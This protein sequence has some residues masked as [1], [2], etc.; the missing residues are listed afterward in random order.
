MVFRGSASALAKSF[1]KFGPELL[2]L[3]LAVIYRKAYQNPSMN[4]SNNKMTSMISFSGWFSQEMMRENSVK[5]TDMSSMENLN[6][7]SN[8]HDMS[9]QKATKIMCHLA[10]V[11]STVESMAHHPGILK[12]LKDII[13]SRNQNSEDQLVCFT[14]TDDESS[15]NCLW[16][17][18]N[19]AC[20]PGNMEHMM[21]YPGLQKTL[22]NVIRSCNPTNYQRVHSPS[23]VKAIAAAG[24]AVR[25]FLNLSWTDENKTRMSENLELIDET[26]KLV[27]SLNQQSSKKVNSLV[28]STR[29]HAIGTLRN[30]AAT[31]SFAAKLRLC[32]YQNNILLT[33][34][35]KVITDKVQ[36][37]HMTEG[38]KEDLV[39]KERALA[40]IYNLMCKETVNSIAMHDG[41]YNEIS[42]VPNNLGKDAGDISKLVEKVLMSFKEHVKSDMECYN[43]ITNAVV[44]NKPE[45]V[46]STTE[47]TT[48]GE[49]SQ[50]T[51][52]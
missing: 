5:F 17:L 40:T 37:D 32:Q 45:R 33:S 22:L 30:I 43:M 21:G 41:L 38:W 12:V 3:L 24:Q 9:I 27:S 14:N 16:I 35:S 39:M 6:S 15:I 25:V 47:V 48:Q 50:Y 19:L 26:I 2:D 7:S 28:L 18:G 51:R 52:I 4:E 46:P 29:R 20:S 13:D 36:N 42:Q 49:F 31:P 34:L 10:R 23:F 1:E 11:G 44:D 8:N